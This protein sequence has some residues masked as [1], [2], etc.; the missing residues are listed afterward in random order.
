MDW[1]GKTAIVT[2]ASG[3]IGR[4]VCK[5]L[6]SMQINHFLITPIN[7]KPRNTSVYAGSGA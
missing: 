3:G 7:T 1:K 2:G 4:A 6:A 5:R